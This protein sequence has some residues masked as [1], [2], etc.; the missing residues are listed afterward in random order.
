[1]RS[2]PPLR[3]RLW[4]RLRAGR[5]NSP[6]PAGRRRWIWLIPALIVAV[7][8]GGAAVATLTHHS[9]PSAAS[10][11]TNTASGLY[12]FNDTVRGTSFIVQTDLT[13]ASAG[14]FTFVTSTGAQYQGGQADDLQKN[15][16]GTL[17][18]HFDGNA[19]LI[20]APAGQTQPAPTTAA[21]QINAVVDLSNARATAEL[22]DSTNGQHFVMVTTIPGGERQVVDAV[23]QAAI[24]QDWATLYG[25]MS[26]SVTSQVTESQFAALMAQQVAA[27]G[28]IT[29]VTV[30]GSPVVGTD[31]AGI[32]YFTIDETVTVTHNGV[33]QSTPMTSYFLLESGAWKL[34][35]SKPA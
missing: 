31:Q 8:A 25:L 19:R 22:K 14:T 4:Q 24:E 6:W 28:A 23:N 7:V 30:T 12:R 1:M 34:F 17:G 13:A 21:V 10:G 27:S 18:L 11:E 35:T 29:A 20:P 5:R 16:D 26:A 3:P 9:R 33:S 32:T 15:G 2:M